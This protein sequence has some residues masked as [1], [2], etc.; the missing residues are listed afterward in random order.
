MLASKAT[1]LPNNLRVLVTARPETDIVHALQSREHILSKTIGDPS[2]DCNPAVSLDL[3]AADTGNPS[4]PPHLRRPG[5]REI[6]HYAPNTY[7]EE[8]HP[9]PMPFLY[10]SDTCACYDMWAPYNPKVSR[11]G[12]TI[13][14]PALPRNHVPSNNAMMG[15]L[16]RLTVCVHLCGPS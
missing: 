9:G 16:A 2:V 14:D 13:S 3:R 6:K 11:K 7:R 15:E 10:P 1:E 5:L 12:M 8:V 4:L